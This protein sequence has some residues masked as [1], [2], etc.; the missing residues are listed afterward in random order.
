MSRKVKVS[1]AVKFG[2]GLPTASTGPKGSLYVRLDGGANTT[3]YV[4]E[5][6]GAVAL[7]SA[8]LDAVT[9]ANNNTVTI[10][11]QVY[12]FKSA[13]SAGPTVP[14]E[15]LLGASDS[16]SL[17][18]LIAAINGAAGVGTTYSTGTVANAFVTAAAGAGDTMVVSAKAVGPAGN[19]IAVSQTLTS[20]SWSSTATTG[21]AF[22]TGSGWV[23]K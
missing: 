1:A 15:V 19:G 6:A 13:L 16:D 9:V 14:N 5:A 7:G 20:G 17:D 12:T 10:G 11:G 22:D 23:A 2:N 3:L 18:N 8:T 21:G 4:R